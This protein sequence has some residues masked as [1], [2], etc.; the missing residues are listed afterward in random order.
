MLLYTF[1]YDKIGIYKQQTTENKMTKLN[2]VYF[3]K[4]QFLK[5]L[6]FCLRII[7][8]PTKNNQYYVC[9]HISASL[10]IRKVNVYILEN[11]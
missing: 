10:Q 2:D 1:L 7:S 4:E 5:E 9:E 3:T 11:K 6:D 8:I